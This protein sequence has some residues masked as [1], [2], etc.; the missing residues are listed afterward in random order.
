MALI[1]AASPGVHR[2]N[3]KA[4]QNVYVYVDYVVHDKLWHD[5]VNRY[6]RVR[7]ASGY[8][9]HTQSTVTAV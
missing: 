1:E 5:A 8:A 9:P 7:Q 6:W 3:N 2:L 4:F